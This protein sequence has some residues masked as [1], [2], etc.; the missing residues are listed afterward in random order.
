MSKPFHSMMICCRIDWQR[1]FAWILYI[2]FLR[3]FVDEDEFAIGLHQI[4][5]KLEQFISIIS[6]DLQL[7]ILHMFVFSLWMH[8]DYGIFSNEMNKFQFHLW[9]WDTILFH[10]GQSSPKC[11]SQYNWKQFVY[12]IVVLLIREALT[13]SE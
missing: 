12:C 10:F 6:Y 5:R 13:G 9:W 1:K 11:Q 7:S 8:L 4:V 3:L 2:V